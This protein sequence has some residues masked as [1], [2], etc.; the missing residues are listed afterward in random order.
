LQSKKRQKDFRDYLRDHSDY[1]IKISKISEYMKRQKYVPLSDNEEVRALLDTAR[2]EVGNTAQKCIVAVNKL[3]E[4]IRA[5]RPSSSA[6]LPAIPALPSVVSNRPNAVNGL[7]HTGP[8]WAKIAEIKRAGNR[9]WINL[10]RGCLDQMGVDVSH[11]TPKV[12]A[13]S[14]A[15]AKKVNEATGLKYADIIA[16]LDQQSLGLDAKH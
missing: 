16:L 4:D 6:E 15:F 5:T 2:N 8:D 14:R 11:G 9:S 7:M 3:L 10:R 13:S 12:R 1:L